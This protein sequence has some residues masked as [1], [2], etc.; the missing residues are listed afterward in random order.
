MVA[1]SDDD[2]T[3]VDTPLT[4]GL[5]NSREDDDIDS[6]GL[7]PLSQQ[8]P[9]VSSSSSYRTLSAGFNRLWRRLPDSWSGETDSER[10]LG[11]LLTLASFIALCVFVFAL[12][13]LLHFVSPQAVT[14]P[15]TAP[16][17]DEASPMIS[18]LSGAVAADHPDCSALGVKVLNEMSGNAVDAMVATVL[19]QGV[20]APFASG[21][22]GGAFILVHSAAKQTSRFYD[23]RE[24]APSAS[25]R[26]MFVKAKKASA[27]RF[28]GLAVGV[29]GELRGLHKAHADWGVLPWSDVV[30]P[31]A[32]LAKESTVGP[33]LALRLKQMNNTVHASPS[34]TAIFTK[35][36]QRRHTAA[37]AQSTAAA[38]VELPG[39]R[40][41]V[42]KEANQKKN[43]A[44]DP[45]RR[46][47]VEMSDPDDANNSD[48]HGVTSLP[49]NAAVDGNAT[50]VNVVLEEGDP[51]RNL[52]LA[53][54]LRHIAER[55]PDFF[56][57]TLAAN[58]SRDIRDAGGIMKKSD[59][60]SYRVVVR[61]PLVSHYH[62][63][64]ILGAP[65]PSS[66]G[67]CVGMTLNIL[68]GF[69]FRSFGRNALAYGRLV[70]ALKWVFAARM[71]LGDPAFVP[72]A[73][74][75]VSRMLSR[76]LAMKIRGRIDVSRTYGPSHYG[77]RIRATARDSGTTH[78]SCPYHICSIYSSR[79]ER[80]VPMMTKLLE[81]L[82]TYAA[83]CPTW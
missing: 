60:S 58:F 3:T 56:Y 43:A 83:L 7:V 39:V 26:T 13:S 28:G 64:K 16:N 9:F 10:A 72:R 29:P 73:K 74:T 15:G 55:G 52:Q 31:A 76:R 48:L 30:L 67:A 75:A 8:R 12:P 49:P 59:I 1:D 19:C 34:L 66:G 38:S 2:E 77:R 45:G 5:V 51:I 68:E 80:I 82:H 20:L 36:K 33:L 14:P 18:G 69:K 47:G 23:A 70:E 25:T 32:K 37:D 78:V 65:L 57:D 4:A 11:N 27:S 79:L 53:S 22:G 6:A 21:I 24:I 41:S 17:V 71:E 40:R 61:E 62:N 63:V 81:S 54:T 46:D 42:K 44:S 35:K 50:Y